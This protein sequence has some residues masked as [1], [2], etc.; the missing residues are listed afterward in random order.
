MST[1]DSK[2]VQLSQDP[3]EVLLVCISLN[4]AASGETTYASGKI[5][6]LA[7]KVG[8]SIPGLQYHRSIRYLLKQPQDGIN[9]HLL[10][11]TKHECNEG[12]L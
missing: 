1:K 2:S 11:S 4:I 8:V 5:G 12:K 6:L 9:S 7:S 3:K 10:Q